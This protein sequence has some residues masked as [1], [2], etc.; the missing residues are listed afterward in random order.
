MSATLFGMCR[1]WP[2]AGDRKARRLPEDTTTRFE[3]DAL[4]KHDSEVAHYKDGSCTPEWLKLM[5]D[6]EHE[7]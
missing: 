2:G 5:N 3:S 1:V 7:E 6:M 4:P